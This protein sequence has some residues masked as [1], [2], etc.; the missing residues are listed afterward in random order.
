MK[1]SSENWFEQVRKWIAFVCIS[2]AASVFWGMVVAGAV[3]YIF[4]ISQ[5]GAFFFVVIPTVL[6]FSVFFIV[7][8]ERLFNAMGFGNAGFR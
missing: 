3:R 4:E 5:E 2:F 8:R 7:I 1:Y 6:A